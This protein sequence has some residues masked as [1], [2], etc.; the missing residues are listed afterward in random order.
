MHG[1]VDESSAV[2]TDDNLMLVAPDLDVGVPDAGGSCSIVERLERLENRF[3]WISHFSERGL[4]PNVQKE[5]DGGG[6]ARPLPARST[7]E[8]R[9]SCAKLRAQKAGAVTARSRSSP[10]SG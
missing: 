4:S 5:S 6:L 1:K 3:K 8:K 10:P 9:P 7:D 2:S